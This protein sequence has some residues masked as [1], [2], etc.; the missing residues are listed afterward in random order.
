MGVTASQCAQRHFKFGR[1]AETRRVNNATFTRLKTAG[2][3]ANVGF[4]QADFFLSNK[5]PARDAYLVLQDMLLT[6][7]SRPS[8]RDLVL[9]DRELGQLLHALT[10]QVAEC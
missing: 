1:S 5:R 6:D 2:G 9:S 10:D 3:R 8:H 4:V 7:L